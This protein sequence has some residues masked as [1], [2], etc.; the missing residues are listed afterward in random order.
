MIITHSINIISNSVKFLCTELYEFFI[1]S[2]G[3]FFITIIF[4]SELDPN[5]VLVFGPSDYSTLH[6]G[7]TYEYAL[8]GGQLPDFTQVE[9]N[10]R[11]TV[12]L[13][14]I[15]LI[16]SIHHFNE[17]LFLFGSLPFVFG[18]LRMIK[19]TMEHP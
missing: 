10:S 14:K 12:R 4:V 15:F 19:E 1:I 9:N 7:G 16:H 11:I 5:F 3:L 18:W 8:L 17:Y 2:H 13:E 6:G